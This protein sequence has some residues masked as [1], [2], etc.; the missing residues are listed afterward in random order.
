LFTEE[1]WLDRKE[2]AAR[3]SLK[4]AVL[5]LGDDM[6]DALHLSEEARAQPLLKDTLVSA[7]DL[8]G[9]DAALSMIEGSLGLPPS[10][11]APLARALSKIQT[12]SSLASTFRT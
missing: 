11:L 2:A 4:R 6:C 5:G 12:L 3:R 9:S 1:E 8:L 7:G 10:P